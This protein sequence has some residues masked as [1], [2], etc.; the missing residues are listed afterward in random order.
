VCRG[1]FIPIETLGA[2]LQMT[3][4]WGPI[5]YFSP[6]NISLFFNKDAWY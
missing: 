6:S 5:L 1:Y 4:D 3:V 2:K